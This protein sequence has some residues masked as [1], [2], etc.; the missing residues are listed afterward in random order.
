M[1]NEPSLDSRLNQ[2]LQELRLLKIKDRY[3]ELACRAARESWP[4]E[5]YLLELLDCEYKAPQER[6]IAARLRQ[7]G[8]PA[9]KNLATLNLKLFPPETISR[10]SILLDGDFLNHRKNVFVFGNTGNGKTHLLCA[11][12]HE[13]IRKG[14]SVFFA[15]ANQLAE[16][17]FQAKRDLKLP[18]LIRK[19]SR[20]DAI[21][22]D[23]LESV[24]QERAKI[25]VLIS[26]LKELDNQASL[27]I[28]CNMHFQQREHIFKISKTAVATVKKLI[29][30]SV[31]LELDN[32]G[33]RLA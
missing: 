28:T 19:L 17:L 26:S 9:G 2:Y 29:R 25:D 20:F 15:P 21:F 10:I 31:I 27:M 11:V 7:S 33:S 8:L 22:I 5:Y 6:K 16:K 18:H 14:W 13:L 1:K 4:Y 32:P 12:S 24:P 23:A 3:R 30:S